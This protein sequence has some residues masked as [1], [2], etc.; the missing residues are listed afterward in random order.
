MSQDVHSRT[1]NLL[2]DELNSASPSIKCVGISVWPFIE[3][4]CMLNIFCHVTEFKFSQEMSSVSSAFIGK[5]ENSVSLKP[6]LF[7]S[8]ELLQ[9]V[10]VGVKLYCSVPTLVHTG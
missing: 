9:F 4:V 10:A 3:F 7:N 2:D 6:D 5:C 1:L 8:F